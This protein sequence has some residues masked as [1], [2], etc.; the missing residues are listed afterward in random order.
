MLMILCQSMMEDVSPKR[1]RL[2]ILTPASSL[3]Y[4]P[5]SFAMNIS[6]FLIYGK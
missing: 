3:G 1:P 5:L 6:K 4:D 2:Y